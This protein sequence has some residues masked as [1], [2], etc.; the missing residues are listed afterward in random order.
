M[1]CF[2]TLIEENGLY[3]LSLLQRRKKA[4]IFFEFFMRVCFFF[5]VKIK[6]TNNV[7]RK[8]F[9]SVFSMHDLHAK[10]KWKT[11]KTALSS[12][13][14]RSAL[15][16]KWIYWT[17]FQDML[18]FLFVMLC[19]CGSHLPFYATDGLF[20]RCQLFRC[21]NR[22]KVLIFRR[23]SLYHQQHRLNSISA[24]FI[25]PFIPILMRRLRHWCLY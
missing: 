22:T 1:L 13:Y 9:V 19:Y 5:N 17:C 18:R 2:L 4:T 15:E 6:I 16:L 8:R 14:C 24:N 25:R 3:F 11:K 21:L 7:S 10:T 23:T 12:R 20:K